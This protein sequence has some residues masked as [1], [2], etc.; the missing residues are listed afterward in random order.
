MAATITRL[1]GID[2]IDQ[3]RSAMVAD[4]WQ[5]EKPRYEGSGGGYW[6]E[7]WIKSITGR[8]AKIRLS[9]SKPENEWQCSAECMLKLWDGGTYDPTLQQIQLADV[10]DPTAL[11][12]E[13]DAAI[14]DFEA[15][16][17]Q[18]AVGMGFPEE[19]DLSFREPVF[20]PST[21]HDPRSY[22]TEPDDRAGRK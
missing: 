7:N 15:R 6:Q 13:A 12:A 2:P 16:R 4:G 21:G 3:Y 8:P 9:A 1:Q 11:Q 17:S 19:V 18:Y 5:L 10:F 22:P 20:T 14:A